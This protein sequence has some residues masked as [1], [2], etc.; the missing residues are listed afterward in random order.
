MYTHTTKIR[1]RYGETDQMGYVYYGNYAE[2]YEVARVEMLR[3]LGMDY[4]GMESAGVMMPVLELNCKY[5]KP[6]LYDQEIT[7]KTTIHDLPG[8]RIHFKYELSNPAGELINIGTTTL[9]FVDMAKNKPCS[10]PENFMEK[11]RVF[12]N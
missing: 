3:S 9:V 12:F 10:P 2:Y 8:V 4:V 11:L 6:A 7:I 5:I 1:V